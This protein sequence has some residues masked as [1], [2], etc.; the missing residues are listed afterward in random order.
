MVQAGGDQNAFQET[1]DGHAKR[2]GTFDGQRQG[3]DAVLGKGPQLTHHHAEQHGDGEHDDGDKTVAGVN[4]H[5]A[6]KLY[7]GV[8]VVQIAGKRSGQY[9]GK[10]PHLQ[11]LHAQYHRLSGRFHLR[12]WRQR[13]L[14]LQRDVHGVDEYDKG[15]QAN[16]RGIAFIARCQ[17]NRNT[18][19]KHQRQVNQHRHGRFCDQLTKMLNQRM[20]EKRQVLGEITVTQHVTKGDKQTDDR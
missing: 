7:A 2:P 17:A 1:V 19:G 3:A 13:A 8:F 9:P 10:D 20:T 6:V 14:Q 15:D 5:R 12:R 16:Q 4:R 18:D 11:H